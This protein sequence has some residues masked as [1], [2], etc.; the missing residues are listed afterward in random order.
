VAST[1]KNTF[2][3]QSVIRC[4]VYGVVVAVAICLVATGILSALIYNGKLKEMY[5]DPVS[6]AI[7]FLAVL[8]GGG[9]SIKL[10]KKQVAIICAITSAVFTVI[11]LSVNITFFNATFSEFWVEFLAIVLGWALAS[12]IGA[13]KKYKK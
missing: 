5:A 6:V 7:L 2:K 8:G 4:V 12:F 1:V 3:E 9:V 10:K 13:R 11:L